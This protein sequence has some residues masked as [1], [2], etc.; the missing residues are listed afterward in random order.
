MI[1]G[2]LFY[3]RAIKCYWCR[4]FPGLTGVTAVGEGTQMRCRR[5]VL[6]VGLAI[7]FG[8]VSTEG[9]VTYTQS[10]VHVSE[11]DFTITDVTVDGAGTVYYYT[12]A[13]LIERVTS[14]GTYTNLS[15]FG[16]T[17]IKGISPPDPSTATLAT[18]VALQ[19]QE[20]NANLTADSDGNL[21]FYQD[22]LLLKLQAS[23]QSIYRVSGGGIFKTAWMLDGDSGLESSFSFS[24]NTALDA[25]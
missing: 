10:T 5:W 1:F 11:Y 20:N 9:Q 6:G 19:M 18:S 21:Y 17:V 24:G 25:E 15:G 14:D 7:L 12:L 13:R 23:D 4:I 16:S 3:A 2:S 8:S 22:G